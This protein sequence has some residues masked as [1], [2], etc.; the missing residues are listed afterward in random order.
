MEHIPILQGKHHCNAVMTLLVVSVMND[1]EIMGYALMGNCTRCNEHV[2]L[3][4]FDTHYYV[5]HIPK[6]NVDFIVEWNEKLKIKNMYTK[7]KW[8]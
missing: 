7:V 4:I 3:H 6:Q 1:K 2:L 8:R 5:E